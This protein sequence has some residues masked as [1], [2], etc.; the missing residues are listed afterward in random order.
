MYEKSFCGPLVGIEWVHMPGEPTTDSFYSSDGPYALQTPGHNGSVC[1]DG[2][3]LADGNPI[4]DGNANPGRG[5]T[6]TLEGSAI[7]TGNMK[8]RLRPLNID[9]VDASPYETSNDNTLLPLIQ[10]GNNWV[11]PITANGDFLLDGGKTYIMPAGTYYFR[12]LVLTGNSTLNVSGP[13]VIYLTR[14]LET[15]GGYLINNTEDASNLQIL[16]QGGPNTSAIVTSAVDLY[17]VIFA[18][19]SPVELRGSAAFYG[20]AVGKTLTA[21]GSG[22]IHYDE[23]LEL[24]IEELPSRLALV[25]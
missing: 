15:S 22:A 5:Q 11:S 18:P 7:V 10:K 17:A 6:T 23:N 14:N 25:K 2:W 12:D 19:A 3:I 4:I 21:T 13:V 9:P 20:A 16:M 1:S 24:E 8:P